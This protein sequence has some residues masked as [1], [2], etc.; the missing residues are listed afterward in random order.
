MQ[1]AVV[2]LAIA[3]VALGCAPDWL[4]NKLGAKSANAAA[5]AALAV[6]SSAH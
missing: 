5:T 1:A 3:V 6:D 4:L 2:A